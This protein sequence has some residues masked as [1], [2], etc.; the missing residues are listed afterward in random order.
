MSVLCQLAK[1]I[2]LIRTHD[3][4][5]VGL[6]RAVGHDTDLQTV[7]L[8]VLHCNPGKREG[9]RGLT[10]MSLFLCQTGLMVLDTALSQ[11]KQPDL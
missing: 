2:V 4:L 10:L 1:P 7:S 3:S 11:C 5:L 6:W 8:L 9:R